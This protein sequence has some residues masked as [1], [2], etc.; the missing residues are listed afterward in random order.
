VS[1]DAERCL[2]IVNE[3]RCEVRLPWWMSECYSSIQ[4]ENHGIPPQ[5]LRSVLVIIASV[6]T[7]PDKYTISGL[8]VMFWINMVLNNKL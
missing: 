4:L 7:N 6:F 8:S 5:Y 2:L 1:E 3:K